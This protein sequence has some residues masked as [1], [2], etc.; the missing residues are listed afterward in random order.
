MDRAKFY[1][2]VEKQVSLGRIVVFAFVLMTNHYHFL[3]MSPTGE[4]DLAMRDIFREY[5]LYFNSRHGRDGP[6]YRARYS[7]KPVVTSDYKRRV[8]WYI[9][10]NPVAAGIVERAIDYPHGSAYRFHRGIAPS[11]LNTEWAASIVE[12]MHGVVGMPVGTYGTGGCSRFGSESDRLVEAR[13]NSA[14]TVDPLD[15]SLETEEERN[16]F[17]T[18]YLGARE[19]EALLMEMPVAA[20]ETVIRVCRSLEA[21]EGPWLQPARR[22]HWDLF[23]TARMGLLKRMAGFTIDEVAR[24]AGIGRSAA[25]RA[26]AHHEDRLARDPGYR[27]RVHG[28]ARAVLWGDEVC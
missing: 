17:L 5:V 1:S 7:S 15:R 6:L 25:A 3:L 8:L 4:L 23:A 11:W 26:L 20:A 28:I 13:M 21:A 10:R 22:K 2:L 16:D 19:P 24:H 9:D 18:E 14:G 27:T 12:E